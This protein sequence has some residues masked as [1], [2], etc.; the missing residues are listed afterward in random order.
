MENG[1]ERVTVR[2]LNWVRKRDGVG[3]RGRGRG[4]EGWGDGVGDSVDE[5]RRVWL[6]RR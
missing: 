4:G 6:M 2:G 1:W 3:G 5:G